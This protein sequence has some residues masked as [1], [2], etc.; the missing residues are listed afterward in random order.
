MDWDSDDPDDLILERLPQNDPDDPCP[1]GPSKIG[2]EGTSTPEFLHRGGVVDPEECRWEGAEMEVLQRFRQR[3]LAMLDMLSIVFGVR[4][5]EPDLLSEFTTLPA[6]MGRFGPWL[7]QAGNMSVTV[8]VI[9]I[10]RF[11]PDKIKDMFTPHNYYFPDS[12]I[13]RGVR[14]VKHD[15]M[16]KV[17]ALAG[18]LSIG[19]GMSVYGFF[20]ED[21]GPRAVTMYWNPDDH[22]PALWFRYR[23][24]LRTWHE[25]PAPLKSISDH[26]FINMMEVRDY[27]MSCFKL[28]EQHFNVPMLEDWH[29]HE[30]EFDPYSVVWGN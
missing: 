13:R 16:I 4:F 21:I 23:E 28:L 12:S 30:F 10:S 18:M 25:Q 26:M 9:P 20:R 6:R 8:P 7:P 27:T 22:P 11:F 3:F 24:F 1:R 19:N 5:S 17:S 2:Y 29:L 15:N 14:V